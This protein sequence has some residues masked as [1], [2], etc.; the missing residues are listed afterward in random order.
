MAVTTRNRRWQDMDKGGTSLDRLA[1]HFEAY[2]RS[3]GKSPKTIIWYSRVLRYFGDYLDERSLPDHL[4]DLD[5]DVVREFVLHLQTRKKWPDRQCRLTEE[6]LR[7]ISVQSYVRALRGFFSWLYREGYTGENILANLKPPKA[8]QR[9]AEVLTDEEVS[10]ILSCL[11]ADTSWGCRATAILTTMLDTGLRLSEVANL[12]MANAHLDEGYLKVM[13]KG[14]KER[15]VPIGGFAQRVLM[16]YVYH[17]RP[18]PISTNED[19]LFLTFD[20]RVMS[21]NAVQMVIGRVGRMS[22]VKRLHP[23]LCRHTFATNYLVNGGDVFTLQ[24]ILGHTTLEMV[25]RYVNL[26]SAHVRVQHRK[27]SPMDKMD[28]K[29]FRLGRIHRGSDRRQRGAAGHPL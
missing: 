29:K 5:I 2:N 3:E 28:L 23:H 13:G 14:A 15:I 1:R 18:E 6:N 20:G 24:Q 10:R 11:D 4:E 26:A 21:G 9:L 22:G 16:R 27:F 8:P 12:T 25:R 19:N 17:F 7:A